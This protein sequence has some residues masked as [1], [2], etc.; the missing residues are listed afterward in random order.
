VRC[1]KNTPVG[2]KVKVVKGPAQAIYA[3][4][5][6]TTTDKPFKFEKSLWVWL[7]CDGFNYCSEIKYLEVV[8][9]KDALS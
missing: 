8:D 2:T 7:R 4:W 9:G 5:I 1:D 6:W 3:S